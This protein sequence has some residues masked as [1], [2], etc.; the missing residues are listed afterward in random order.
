MTCSA[1]SGTGYRWPRTRLH[2]SCQLFRSGLLTPRR[3]EIRPPFDAV[4]LG[5]GHNPN[6]VPKVPETCVGS[7]YA[8]PLCIKPERG[9]VSENTVKPP[10]K[11]SCD[12]LHENEFDFSSFVKFANNSSVIGP[13]AASF[14]VKTSAFAG[15][16][17]ILAWEAAADDINSNSV[18]RQPLSGEAPDIFVLR[19]IGPMLSQ[20]SATE[21]IDLAERNGFKSSGSLKT[22][23]EAADA[24]KQIED[25]ERHR[26]SP[27]TSRLTAENAGGRCPQSSITI[28]LP[29]ICWITVCGYDRE[30]DHRYPDD[31]YS[32]LPIRDA[33]GRHAMAS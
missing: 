24:R 7:R 22:K 16:A 31:P 33:E 21:W 18:C 3:G 2:Q 8:V 19:D 12:V 1:V 30:D 11:E 23:R 29:H 4:A 9:Q 20:N 26:D 13:E 6:S 17:D 5:V 32:D 28:D 14:S 25:P 27:I 15:K 10:S